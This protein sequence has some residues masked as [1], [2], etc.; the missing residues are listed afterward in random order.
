MSTRQEL[1]MCNE[2]LRLLGLR[3]G[4]MVMAR[5]SWL[6]SKNGRTY[7]DLF[8]RPEEGW[9]CKSAT[10][11]RLL[12]GDDLAARLRARCAKARDAGIRQPVLDLAHAGRRR[13]R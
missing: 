12:I 3:S 8:N 6:L 13:L 10:P 7:L 9:S 4:E 5:E 1:A 11:G 2:V